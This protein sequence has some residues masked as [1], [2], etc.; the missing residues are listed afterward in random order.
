MKRLFIL[1][2]LINLC[3]SKNTFAQQFFDKAT[4]EFEVKT[5]VK[6]SMGN[7]S[8]A[9]RM[10]DMLP[11]FKTSYYTFTFTGNKS[12]YQF[13][14]WEPNSK[15]PPFLKG[16]DEASKWYVDH[17]TGTMQMKKDVFGTVFDI[18]D[19][20]TN[21]E[22]KYTNESRVIAGFNCRKAVGVMMDSV[23]VFAFYTDELMISGG[24]CS[25]NGL[26]GMVLGVTIPRLYASW[27]ATKVNVTSVNENVV[28]PLSGKK[29][30]SLTET[31]KL[32]VDRTKEWVDSD[33]PSGTN[34]VDQLKWSVM[35]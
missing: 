6:K 35:L 4:V 9:E 11:Q 27:M 18:E 28:T 3:I 14:H 13:S 34:W 10:K 12:I 8:W 24:P 7:S 29:K 17:N 32:I 33:D 5:N 16:S 21:I 20:L 31:G 26:P 19:S 22:W 25:I 15:L 1:S 30:Y 2:L 23:Y